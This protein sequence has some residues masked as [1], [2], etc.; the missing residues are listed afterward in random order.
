MRK[1]A[2]ILTGTLF[3]VS[4]A[5]AATIQLRTLTIVGPVSAGGNCPTS[6]NLPAPVARGTVL[7]TFA[8]T[9]AGWQ[10]AVSNPTGG[11]DSDK[12]VVV[13]SG[14]NSTLEVEPTS[15]TATGL[16]AGNGAYQLGF[17]TTTP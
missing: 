3:V 13:A 2:I 16:A 15:L 6:A 5:I 10:G 8:I 4:P 7:Y 9:L 17:V 12:F 1:L 11:A 14:G